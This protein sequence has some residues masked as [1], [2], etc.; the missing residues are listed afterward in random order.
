MSFQALI[1]ARI[2][3]LREAKRLTQE[4]L[5]GLSRSDAATLSRIETGKQNLSAETLANFIV[6]LNVTPKEFFSA[7]TFGAA[8]TANPDDPESVNSEYFAVE[9]VGD[10]A[11][12]HIRSGQHP[13]SL[14]FRSLSRQK[15]VEAVL[16]LRRGLRQ[17]ELSPQVGDS[18]GGQPGVDPSAERA[19]MSSAI[20]EAFLSLVRG[21]PA[22]NPSD[23]WRYIISPAFCD[24]HNHPASSARKDFGQ[25]FK[26]TGGWAFERILVAHY[27]EFLSKHGVVLTKA[28]A[29]QL[30]QSMGLVGQVPLDKIDLFVV[31]REGDSL[32]PLGVI[33]VKSSI[34][35]RRT[36][37]V[38]ASQRV[39]SKGYVSLFVTLD[40]KDT[41]A[42]NPVNK[43]EY[44][45]SLVYDE[46]NATWKGSEKRRDIEVNGAF[47][48]VFSF[49]ARTIESPAA[50]PS[51]HRIVRVSFVNPDDPFSRFILDA[52][53]RLLTA[54]KKSKASGGRKP[55]TK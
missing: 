9:E 35:E 28:D 40:S 3:Q 21:N 38:P 14:D 15:V 44:G 23:V 42:P 10:C 4:Q 2:K 19:L 22:V 55:G 46:E 49:N 17:A 8:L 12:V 6:A 34:A 24:S 43:G 29:N 1:G 48:A 30:L 18:P 37:D 7:D 41:L 13:A 32:F 50:T 26:R 31:A 47:S 45:R 52:K 11:R 33:H 5:A 51:G 53:E 27:S 20:A 36:D 16:I 39:M 25:S 54:A